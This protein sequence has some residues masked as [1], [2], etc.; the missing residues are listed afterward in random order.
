VS[1]GNFCEDGYDLMGYVLPANTIVATQAWSMHRDASVFPSPETFLPDRW[2]ETPDNEEQLMKMGQY[3]MP[4]G[5][6]SRICGG[7]NLAQVTLRIVVALVARNFRIVAPPETNDK[8]MD[9]RDAFVRFIMLFSVSL[10][11]HLARSYFRPL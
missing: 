2:L 10:A 5:T 1:K 11:N 8:T 9:I 4:F 7:Q 3:L 6:G